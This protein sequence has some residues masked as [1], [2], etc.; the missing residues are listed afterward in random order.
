MKTERN[1]RGVPAAKVMPPFSSEYI[2]IHSM[3]PINAGI[4]GVFFRNVLNCLAAGSFDSPSIW[5]TM[6]VC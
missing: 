4:F 2:D 5:N 3:K 1:L 6:H